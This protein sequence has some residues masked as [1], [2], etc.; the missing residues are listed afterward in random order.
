MP[1]IRPLIRTLASKPSPK[2]PFSTS[3][4]NLAKRPPVDDGSL[5]YG[6]EHKPSL[7]GASLGHLVS[8]LSATKP[9]MEHLRKEGETMNEEHR[10]QARSIATWLVGV[11]MAVG[12]TV[13]GGLFVRQLLR[14]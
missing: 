3:A 6:A 12:G 11:P 5:F 13:G 9:G 14:D 10:T 4:Q 8:E 7:G 2:N 1:P